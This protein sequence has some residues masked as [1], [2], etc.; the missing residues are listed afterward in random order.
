MLVEV[1]V[2]AIFG[3]AL[4]RLAHTSSP[5]PPADVSRPSPPPAR[6]G[7]V[8]VPLLPLGANPTVQGLSAGE[9]AWA[10]P[11]AMVTDGDGRLWLRGS[12]PVTHHRRRHLV[13]VR[14]TSDGYLVQDHDRA[15][16]RE[17]GPDWPEDERVLV[18]GRFA[19]GDP[20]A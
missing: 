18:T 20:P 7:P 3:F 15:V 4:G 12:A 5:P 6:S 9:R 10:R 19:P 16:H 8:D 17:E 11:D 14:R 1:V 13:E 2:I